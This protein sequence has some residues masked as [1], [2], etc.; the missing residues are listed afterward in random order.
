MLAEN[1]ESDCSHGS[2][3]LRY[4]KPVNE[5]INLSG[6]YSYRDFI[7]RTKNRVLYFH[8]QLEAFKRGLRPSL[9]AL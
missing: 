6:F 4:T 3:D 1:K 8:T 9:L 7:F 5:S 2:W